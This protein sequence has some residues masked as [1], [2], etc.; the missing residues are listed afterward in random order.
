MNKIFLLL[1]CSFFFLLFSHPAAALVIMYEDFNSGIPANWTVIDN[2]ATGVVWS[3]IAGSGEAGNF[4]GGDG[5][6]ASV[7][8]D[9]SGIADFDTELVSAQFSLNGATSA[10]LSYLANYQNFATED[11][12]DLDLWTGSSWTNLLSW[13]EDH[14]GFRSTPGEAVTI[15]LTPYVGQSSLQ[16]RFHYYDPEP[17]DW[18]WYAQIDNFLVESDAAPVPEPATMLLLGSGLLGIA[19]FGRK[20]FFKK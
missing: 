20:K 16:I 6:A 17:N 9:K 5:D 2:E 3:N 12:L 8:S 10:S 13:N 7:S 11:F 19:G 15:D 4:T 1:L 18:E 14:G